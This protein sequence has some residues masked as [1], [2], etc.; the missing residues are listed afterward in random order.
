MVQNLYDQSRGYETAAITFEENST[1]DLAGS[2]MWLKR[3]ATL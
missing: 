2:L 1:G 3:Q